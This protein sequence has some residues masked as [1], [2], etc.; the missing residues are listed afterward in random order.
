MNRGGKVRVPWGPCGFDR[1]ATITD[2][3][4]S[5]RVSLWVKTDYKIIQDKCSKKRTEEKSSERDLKK[6]IR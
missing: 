5:V 4:G 3:S 6:D 2:H 1:A